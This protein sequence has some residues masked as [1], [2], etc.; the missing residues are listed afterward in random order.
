MI[1]ILKCVDSYQQYDLYCNRG[2]ELP[3]HEC[4]IH[5]LKA[6]KKVPCS[7]FE[8]SHV[9]LG[10]LALQ[11]LTTSQ[12]TNMSVRLHEYQ[13]SQYFINMF[14]WTHPLNPWKKN[15]KT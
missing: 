10:K 3:D 6:T 12:A 13:I 1:H 5:I 11:M 9:D 4:V 15:K 14:L 8:L 2:V 7:K